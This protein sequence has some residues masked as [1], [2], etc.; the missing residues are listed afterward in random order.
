[1][2]NLAIS[3][4]V[5]TTVA[6]G[7]WCLNQQNQIKNQ[8]A[9]LAQ[10]ETRLADARAEL[11]K[12]SEAVE[13]AQFAAANEKILQQ[14]L[15]ETEAG[16]AEQSK[17]AEHLEQSL[18]AAKTNNPLQGFAAVFKDP[19]MREM[20]KSQQK[21]VMGPM[22]DKQYAA[23]FQQLNLTPEQTAALKDLLE[24]KTFAGTD[25]GFSMLDSSLDASQRADLAKQV[26]SQTDDIENQIKQLLGD[27]NYQTF[28]SYEQTL[29]DRTAV[30]QFND[31]LAG[32]AN[33][34]TADQQQQL[35]QAMSDVHANFKWTAVLHKPNAADGDYTAMFTEDNINQF[36][37]QQE[38]FN[39]QVFTRAQPILSPDQF[40][41]F[42]DYTA[43][44]QQL[45]MV[46]M[47]MAAQMFAPKSQ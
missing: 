29:P 41:A 31:Q 20:I 30:S 1:M 34:L 36:A 21:A 40:K 7:A 33:A 13:H 16:A 5:L 17:K 45:Q 23:L 28:Q 24:K 43:T 18:A 44:Q 3:I 42:Q 35:L 12:Q 32:T 15:A 27:Q 26:K 11:Q 47:K 6:L 39:Q 37:Q 25:A 22:L 9:Q 38:Q 10:T 8:S 14:I 2:K 4:L 19:K 46:G